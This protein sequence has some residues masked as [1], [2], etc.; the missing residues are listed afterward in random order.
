MRRRKTL[1]ASLLQSSLVFRHFDCL[2]HEVRLLSSQEVGIFYIA[3]LRML[4]ML[5]LFDQG[6]VMI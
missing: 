1:N 5:E 6:Y 4:S 2:I 3:P